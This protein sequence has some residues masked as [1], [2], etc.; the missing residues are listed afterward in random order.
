MTNKHMV[1]ALQIVLADSYALYAKTQ[2]Y[3]WNVEGPNF[4]QLHLLFEEQYID[5]ADAIDT[6]A[7]LI[8]GLGEKVQGSLETYIKNTSIN[9]GNES[10]SSQ[11]MIQD[12]IE[13]NDLIKKTLNDALKISQESSDE[14]VAGFLIERLT[15]HRKANWMLNS[16]L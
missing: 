3:H 16:S 15:I 1:D 12:L 9:S 14:V 10:F 5:L 8:R 11:Q 6:I 13:S 2:N 7:E 4:K